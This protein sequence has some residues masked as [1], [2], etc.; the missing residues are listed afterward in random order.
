MI[1][2]ALQCLAERLSDFKEFH[3]LLLFPCVWIHTK[4]KCELCFHHK[5]SVSDPPWHLFY[6]FTSCNEESFPSHRM[7][8]HVLKSFLG[9]IF[10]LVVKMAVGFPTSSIRVPGF[11]SWLCFLFPGAAQSG[12][13][14]RI[15]QSLQ[16]L[17]PMWVIWFELQVLS[18]SVICTWL[19]KACEK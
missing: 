16:S 19:L 4:K 7:L 15:A 8:L 12:K 3:I 2:L 18:F 10:G 14:Q 5:N 11:K 13:R 9:W 1:T 6:S 17:P